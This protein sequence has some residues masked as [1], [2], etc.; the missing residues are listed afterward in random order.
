MQKNLFNLKRNS[1]TPFF[2]AVPEIP[3]NLPKKYE[4]QFKNYF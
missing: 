2:L 1:F 4:L 3:L